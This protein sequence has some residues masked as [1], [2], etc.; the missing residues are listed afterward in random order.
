MI[1]GG[2]SGTRVA[3]H[4]RLAIRGGGQTFA[5]SAAQHRI[6]R[7]SL[8]TGGDV[9]LTKRELRSA[10]LLACLNLGKILIRGSGVGKHDVFRVAEGVTVR[11]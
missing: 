7:L 2:H 5:I 8:Q 4:T 3:P 6:L 11:P 10:E 1:M 9:I